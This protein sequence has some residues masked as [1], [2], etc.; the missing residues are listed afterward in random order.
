[1]IDP[2]LFR[3]NSLQREFHFLHDTL[4]SHLS[5]ELRVYFDEDTA[6]FMPLTVSQNNAVIW[7]P[8]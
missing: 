4:F 6:P 8:K 7:I 1:V 5:R 2:T 3:R